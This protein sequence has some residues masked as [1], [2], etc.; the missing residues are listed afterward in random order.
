L[1]QGSQH[2]GVLATFLGTVCCG[3]LNHSVAQ[4]IKILNTI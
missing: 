3:N 4:T 1:F 2:P